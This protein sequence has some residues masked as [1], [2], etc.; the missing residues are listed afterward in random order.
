MAQSKPVK[1]EVSRTVI[2]PLFYMTH[3][4]IE[5]DTH[6][7]DE[8]LLGLHHTPGLGD[9]LH[10]D[11]LVVIQRFRGKKSFLQNF[12]CGRHL[13][14]SENGKDTNLSDCIKADIV[15]LCS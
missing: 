9:D 11:L 12:D 6:R 3:H 5:H 8:V 4:L 14:F 13:Y 1:L 15:I 10:G 2:L 7:V